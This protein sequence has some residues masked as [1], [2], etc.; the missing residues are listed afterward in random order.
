MQSDIMQPQKKSQPMTNSVPVA[1]AP[2]QQN[3]QPSQPVNMDIKAEHPQKLVEQNN[4]PQTPVKKVKREKK[5]KYNVGIIIVAVIIC[6]L[7]A[8]LAVYLQLNRAE[9]IREQAIT[10]ISLV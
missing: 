10:D 5:T 2:I 3:Q 9:P 6:A 4:A 8:G 1:Q 7:L